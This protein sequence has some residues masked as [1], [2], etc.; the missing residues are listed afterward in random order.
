MA[1]PSSKSELI[2]LKSRDWLRNQKHAGKAVGNALRSCAHA[3]ESGQ[4]LTLRD[5]EKLAA[6]EIDALG[7]H[8]TFLGYHGFPAKICTSVNKTL[9]HGIPSDYQ[10]QEG[11]VVTVDLGA[12]YQGAIADA[13]YTAVCGETTEQVR[14]ML[15]L[16]QGALNAAIESIKVGEPLGIIGYSIYEHVRN[17]QFGLITTYGGHGID[18]DTLHA[19]PFVSNKSR[20][21]EGPRIQPGLSIAIEPMLTLTKNTNTKT[22]S[23]K[24]SIVT[25]DVGCHFEHSVTLDDEGQVHIVTEHGMS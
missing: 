10:L 14:K 8:P 11:D 24:W 25:R 1:I 20:K 3:I 5:L 4:K 12:T 19:A 16:C 23:D 7:C 13:A 6:D 18:T 21:N 22:L 2:V 9:V 17:S 15:V